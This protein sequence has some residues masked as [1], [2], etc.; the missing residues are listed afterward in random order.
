[1][2][3]EGGRQGVGEGEREEVREVG[4]REGR[5]KGG[6]KEGKKG[7]GIRERKCVCVSEREKVRVCVWVRGGGDREGVRGV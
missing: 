1:M 2:Q 5:R 6:R 3:R 4:G 7:R